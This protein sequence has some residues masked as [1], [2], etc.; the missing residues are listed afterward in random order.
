MA[1]PIRLQVGAVGERHLDL[2]EHVAGG[3]WLG[4]WH[5]LDAEVAGAV[6]DERP[7]GTKTTLSASPFRNS[8]SPSSKRSSGSTVGAGRSSSGRSCTAAAM[9]A[10]VA[11]R[12]PTN[13]ELPPVDEV[14][15]EVARV[16]E[17]EQRA[18][19]LERRIASS[20]PAGAQRTTASTGPS[21]ATSR[22]ARVAVDCEDVVAAAG[23]HGGEE[24]ADEA[25]PDDQH[26]PARDTLGATEDACERLDG[27]PPRIVEPVRELD[28]LPAP[29]LA[30][31]SR[32]ARSSRPR[33][34]RMSSRGPTGS[35]GSPH[36]GCGGRARR[37]VRRQSPRRPRARARARRGPGRAS[38]GRSRRA[39]RR[40]RARARRCLPARRCRRA[41]A[42][43]RSL[44][45][46]HARAYRRQRGQ[47]R[48]RGDEAMAVKLHRCGNM[49]IK[50]DGHP[51][52]RVQ[53]ALDEA[54]VEYE[55]VKESW[56][57][58][59]TPHGGDR[60]DGPERPAGDRARGRQLVPRGL[61]GDGARD[62]RWPPL[63]QLD[64][65]EVATIEAARG[66]SSAG[67]APGSHPGGR[68][69]EPA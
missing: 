42:R 22:S 57:R 67:R 2:D 45:R 54:G 39:R 49:W 9:E 30:R 37:A 12:E 3:L 26:A 60:R 59:K 44:G 27:R 53:K 33:T 23:E 46:R 17:D 69:F 10:G 15:G 5:V 38:R 68:R 64:P 52:W 40:A 16:R 4:P 36:T 55:V 21:G 31:R 41:P 14:E 11:D 61:G 25:V 1:A 43:R 32:R 6:E 24:M 56:P 20:A 47:R 50:L 19:G 13:G 8:A 58:R 7:H 65:L 48:S 66:Y 62:P 51:C 28:P 34:P 18:A 63:G 29:A 35:A